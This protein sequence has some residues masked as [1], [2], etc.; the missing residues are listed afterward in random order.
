MVGG[1]KIWQKYVWLWVHL[2][3]MLLIYLYVCVCVCIHGHT[4][5]TCSVVP[6]SSEISGAVACQV[7]L[8]IGFPRQEYWSISFFRGSSQPRDW[9]HV[10]WVSCIVRQILYHWVTRKAHTCWTKF[11]LLLRS[12]SLIGKWQPTPIFLLGKSHRQRSL[13]GYHP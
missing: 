10:S 2:S 1:I 4:S 7:P 5:C 9:T 8:S 13:V 12:P 11:P 3:I 6:D